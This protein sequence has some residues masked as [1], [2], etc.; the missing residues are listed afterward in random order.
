MHK[1][2]FYLIEKTAQR[3]AEVA[4]RLCQKIYQ[5]HRIWIKYATAQ[6]G[7]KLDLD[8]WQ[9]DASSFLAHGIDQR[10]ANICLSLENPDPDFDVCINL[11]DQAIDL[12]ALPNSSL[13]LIEIVDNN[14]Q[15][16]AQARLRFKYYRQ[17]GIEPKTH[18]I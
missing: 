1:V 16:K 2:S 11:N 5:K 3:Q 14:E 18:R 7:E 10:A 13:H 12:T 4:C 9:F 8:L 15:D 6:D 17:L